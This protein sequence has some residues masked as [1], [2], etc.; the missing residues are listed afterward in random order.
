MGKQKRLTKW[1]KGFYAGVLCSLEHVALYDQ[2]TIFGG[3]VRA[4]G[5]DDLIRV[6]RK[7]GQMRISG[8][9]KYGYGK[10]KG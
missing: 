10:K 6:A 2:E 5:E 1:D 8:L 7:D 9:V 4:V 3:I